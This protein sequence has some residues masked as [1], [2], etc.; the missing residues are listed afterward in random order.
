MSHQRGEQNDYIK[1]GKKSTA[2]YSKGKC[3]A[4]HICSLPCAGGAGMRREGM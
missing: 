2:N 4:L 3:Q 1:T